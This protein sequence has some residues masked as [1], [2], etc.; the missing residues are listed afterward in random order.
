[1]RKENQINLSILK[2]QSLTDANG[3]QHPDSRIWWVALWE[4][5][6]DR[7]DG[8][9]ERHDGD[10]RRSPLEMM[11]IVMMVVVVVMVVM[12]MMDDQEGERHDGD[13]CRPHHNALHPETHESQKSPKRDHDVRVVCSWRRRN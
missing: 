9:G 3:R 10:C 13:C 11:M 7:V 8:E 12:V 6:L 4:E 1:M 2:M 5:R